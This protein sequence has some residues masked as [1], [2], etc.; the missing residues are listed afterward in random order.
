MLNFNLTE[1]K[2]IKY[3]LENGKVFQ[4]DI[5]IDLDLDKS[6]LSRFLSNCISKEILLK[7]KVGKKNLFYFNK[8]RKYYITFE[9]NRKK[10][11]CHITNLYGETVEKISKFSL[12]YD[13]FGS[14]YNSISIGINLSLSKYPVTSFIGICFCIHGILSDNNII[15]HIPN[16]PW[17]NI[18]LIKICK[19]ISSLEVF[20]ENYTNLGA[21]YE[22]MIFYP[23][24]TSLAL[25][26]L[27]TGI[28][29]GLVIE[30]RIYS[31]H[32]GGALEIGHLTLT[33]TSDIEYVDI[34]E[35][36]FMLK[37]ISEFG[38][39]DIKEFILAY[40]NND[41]KASTLYKLFLKNWIF[42]LRNLVSII[43]PSVLLL[44]HVIFNNFPHCIFEIQSAFENS[45]TKPKIISFSKVPL[46]EY[47]RGI[48]ILLFNTKFDLNINKLTLI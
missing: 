43:N 24:H 15:R 39:K 42:M 5:Q 48:N 28:G 18:D 3:I 41:S 14:F 10:L 6:N 13:D 12:D 37:K 22:K 20:I 25:V 7:D 8:N 26:K 31:G 27:Q 19:N 29:G 1:K 47:H 4:N 17:K 21:Y 33:P 44:Y 35:E 23:N 16:C 2:I 32:N 11:E 30:N 38:F 45:L 40:K 36:E 9:W 34:I 46:E